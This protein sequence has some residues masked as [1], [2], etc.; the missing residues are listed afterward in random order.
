VAARRPDQ[1]RRYPAQYRALAG[2]IV[3]S[4]AFAAIFVALTLS[5]FHAPKPHD[6]PVGIVGPAAVTS[7]VSGLIK[8]IYST[9]CLSHSSF[10]IGLKSALGTAKL[11]TV[12]GRLPHTDSSPSKA[13]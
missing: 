7:R 1:A 4:A 13:F 5:A 9:L 6:L 8:S 11:V 3:T 10:G 12:M 2:F